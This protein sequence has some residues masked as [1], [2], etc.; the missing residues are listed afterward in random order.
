MS[1][2]VYLGFFAHSVNFRQP[3]NGESYK[4]RKLISGENSNHLMVCFGEISPEKK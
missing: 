3:R 2:I 4:V 1:F